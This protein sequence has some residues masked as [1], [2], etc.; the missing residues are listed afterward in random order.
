VA[1]MKE[2]ER[3]LDI[4]FNKYKNYGDEGFYFIKSLVIILSIL[5]VSVSF[6]GCESAKDE[7]IKERQALEDIKYN[8]QQRSYAMERE[9]Q[10]G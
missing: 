4:Y 5:L 1:T 7:A 8:A 2:V 3:Q 6:S 9:A 10:N